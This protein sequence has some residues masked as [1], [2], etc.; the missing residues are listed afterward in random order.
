MSTIL[1]GHWWSV[2][3]AANNITVNT[4]TERATECVRLSESSI[5]I[6]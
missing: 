5:I 4:V 3:E 1:A 2:S 6:D